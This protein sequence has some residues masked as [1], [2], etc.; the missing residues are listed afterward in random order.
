MTHPKPQTQYTVV[1]PRKINNTDKTKFQ[2]D[3]L[4]SS[5]YKSPSSDLTTLTDQY[6]TVVAATLDDHAPITKKRVAIKPNYPWLNEDFRSE[7]RKRRTY[8]QKWRKTGLIVHREIFVEQRQLVSNLIKLLKAK[9]YADKIEECGT[10]Q[11]AL[12]NVI[13]S[14]QNKRKEMA[15]P[16][17]GSISEPPDISTSFSSQKYLKSDKNLILIV[18]LI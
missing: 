18:A 10:D 14:L 4:S 9:Y 6:N 2:E 7:K 1:Q 12:F 11:K 3:I 8:E 16:S 17:S 13:N 15:L 5:L